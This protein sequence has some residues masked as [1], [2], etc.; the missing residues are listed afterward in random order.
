MQHNPDADISIISFAN[1]KN[2]KPLF[3]LNNAKNPH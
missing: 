1:Y 3:L 2:P